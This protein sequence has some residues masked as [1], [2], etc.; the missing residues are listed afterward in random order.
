MSENR[1]NDP[2]K[3]LLKAH[4]SNWTIRN[5]GRKSLSANALLAEADEFNAGMSTSLNHPHHEIN[6]AARRALSGIN[7]AGSEKEQRKILSLPQATPMTKMVNSLT[8]DGGLRY[9]D[10][11]ISVSSPSFTLFDP[12]K[13][14]DA[15]K[16]YYL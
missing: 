2:T 15:A 8:S 5:N 6:H 10:A 4:S 12:D 14:D 11:C 7:A 13:S 9:S 1:N 3:A 16:K